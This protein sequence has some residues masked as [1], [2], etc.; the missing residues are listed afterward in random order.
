[1]L[2]GKSNSITIW[3]D[4][5]MPWLCDLFLVLLATCQNNE[6]FHGLDKD[7]IISNS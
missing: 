5:R 1:M 4:K 6:L 7:I 3:I 2:K